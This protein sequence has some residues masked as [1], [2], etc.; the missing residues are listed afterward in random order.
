MTDWLLEITDDDIADLVD[1]LAEWEHKGQFGE[2]MGD[3]MTSVITKGDARVEADINAR[4]ATERAKYQRESAIRKERS[5][6][7]RAK[8]LMIRNRRR[9][10]DVARRITTTEAPR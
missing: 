1:A 10:D 3:L 4:R 2:M 5:V 8:L 9:V 7:L 6:I